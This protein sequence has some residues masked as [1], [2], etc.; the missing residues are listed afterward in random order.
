MGKVNDDDYDDQ[1]M[2][3]DIPVDDGRIITCNVVTI[4]E[5]AGK[6]YIALHPNFED[7]DEEEVIWFYG[8]SENPDNPNEEPE[9][10]YI[11]DNS[12]YEAVCDAYD[13]WLDTLAFEDMDE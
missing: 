8:Y 6:D 11:V 3:V 7:P 2:T 9:L 10:K 12:E 5:V 1:D 4:L 13:E